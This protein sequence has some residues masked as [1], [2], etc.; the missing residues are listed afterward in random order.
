M[1]NE[2]IQEVDSSFSYLILTFILFIVA[3]MLSPLTSNSSKLW[4]KQKWE[5]DDIEVHKV[6]NRPMNFLPYLVYGCKT[7]A[8][9][10][11]D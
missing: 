4:G 11:F 9:F 1:L 3:Y 8:R 7:R 10:K 2:N 5:L 6:V